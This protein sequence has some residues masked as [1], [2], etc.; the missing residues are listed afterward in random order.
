M[1]ARVRAVDRQRQGEA[2]TEDDLQGGWHQKPA[3]GCRGQN[4]A[5]E[6]ELAVQR[7]VVGDL[8]LEEEIRRNL[9]RTGFLCCIIRAVYRKK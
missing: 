5:L 8:R 7:R 4:K 9:T 1:Q 6:R 2:R 3:Y